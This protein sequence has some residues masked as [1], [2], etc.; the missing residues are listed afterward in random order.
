MAS[1]FVYVLVA[2]VA[3]LV[4]GGVLAGMADDTGPGQGTDADVNKGMIASFSPGTIG[5]I[6]ATSRTIQVG[7]V[8]VADQSPNATVATRDSVSVSS[9]VLD[10]S[11]ATVTFEAQ[12]PRRVFLSFT[13]SQAADPD[14][15]IITV[16]GEE[17]DVPPFEVGE[18]VTL[19]SDNVQ[20]GRNS[21]VFR[22]E[23]PGAAF[24]RRPSFTLK[25]VE[26]VVEDAANAGVLKTFRAYPYEVNGFDRGELRFSV[27]E[28]VV[29]DEPL[30]IQING[31]TVFERTP[32]ARALPYTA[33]FSSNETGITAGENVLAVRTGGESRYVLDNL[34]LTMYFFAGT[35]RRT[36]QRDIHILPS[37]YRDLGE[38]NGRITIQVDSVTLQRPVTVE[39]GNATF[40]QTLKA[41]ENVIRFGKADVTKGRNTLRIATDGSYRIPS[42]TVSAA[43]G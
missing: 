36:V 35:Q 28:D 5:S 8:T 31:N 42:I 34:Q 27:T 4:V 33:T 29:R 13:P 10:S 14:D 9:S 16:N 6:D 25:D 40:T 39:L 30:R 15:L 21:I 19:S 24:W 1:E 12:S 7:D 38:D 37:T 18:P 2:G 11:T 41:G 23:D 22:A 17:V 26:V 20:A 3:I 32:V 43:D